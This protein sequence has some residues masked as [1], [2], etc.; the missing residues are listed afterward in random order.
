MAFFSGCWFCQGAVC[1]VFFYGFVDAAVLVV[2]PQARYIQ[3][4]VKNNQR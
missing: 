1:D 2:L 4:W 3:M